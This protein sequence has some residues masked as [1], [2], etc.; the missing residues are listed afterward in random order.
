MKIL[1][2][3]D[4]HG[5]QN[6]YNKIKQLVEQHNTQVV[7]NGG[8][9]LPKHNN[10]FL[11]Q[12]IFIKKYLDQHFADFN[13]K[14][15]YYLNCLG[16]DDLRTHDELFDEVCDKYPFVTNIAQKK[17]D[18]EGYEFIGMN[19]VCDYPFL[20]KDRCR[21]D[22]PHYTFQR[23]FGTGL[24]STPNGYQEINGWHD[25]ALSLP[26]IEDEL[27]NLP[28]S[29]KPQKTI[30]ITHMP[31]YKLGLDKCYQGDEVGSKAV[32]DFIFEVQPAF[33]LHGHIHESPEVTGKWFNQ[34]NDTVCIQP[35]QSR[36]FPYVVIDLAN[37]SFER[38]EL[39]NA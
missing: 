3:T 15:I 10:L 30:Y 8:D 33:T 1:Y 6:K 36:S 39:F 31:P 14:G 25:F 23:Q 26:S 29:N 4:L 21:V 32:Y 28:K 27:R 13:A 5:E 2:F 35:G 19:W 16:N 38:F 11:D 18:I 34:I 37:N 12:R 20:L 17:T 9:M 7:I 24:L 22:G